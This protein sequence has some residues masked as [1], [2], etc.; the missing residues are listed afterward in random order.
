M[1]NFVYLWSARNEEHIGKHNVA[2][3]E[4]EDIVEH[5]KPPYPENAGDEKR[6][7]RGKTRGGRFLQVIFVHASVEDVSVEEFERLK[8]YERVALQAG[9]PAIRVI[10]A[11]GLT[12]G[13]KKQLRRK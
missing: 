2:A 10:H 6:A 11:R 8:M 7:V 12:A 3:E 4:A 1:R 9:E 5:A 13:E